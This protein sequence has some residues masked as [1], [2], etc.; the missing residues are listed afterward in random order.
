MRNGGGTILIEGD[1]KEF[2]AAGHCSAYTFPT[3]N[4]GTED[5]FVCHGYSA[6]KNGM[7][8]LVQRT[9]EWTKDGWPK[10]K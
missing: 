4:G 7:A 10:L 8:L 1:K 9:I 3:A 2:E 6:T 5:I